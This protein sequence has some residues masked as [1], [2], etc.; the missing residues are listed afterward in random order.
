MKTQVCLAVLHDRG[1]IQ[2]EQTADHLRIRVLEPQGKVD[3][4]SA[5]MMKKLHTLAEG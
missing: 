2:M 5:E 3:L 4:E 1:L